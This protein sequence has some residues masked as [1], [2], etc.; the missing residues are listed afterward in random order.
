MISRSLSFLAALVAAL[1]AVPPAGASTG[2][3]AMFQDDAELVYPSRA[4]VGRNLDTLQA[5][6]VDRVRVSVYWRLVAPSPAS[7]TRPSFGGAGPADPAAYPREHWRRYDDLVRLAYDRGIQV[8][9]NIGGPA[10][11]WASGGKGGIVNPR[12]GDF[13]QFVAAVAT[14]YTGSYEPPPGNQNPPPPPPPNPNPLPVEVQFAPRQAEPAAVSSQQPEPRL[15]RVSYWSIYNEPNQRVFLTPQY[16][17]RREWSPRLYRA[18]ADAA[19][20][21][22]VRTGHGGDTVLVGET[23]PKG[24]GERDPEANMRPLRFLRALYCVDTRFRPLRGATAEALGCPTSNQVAEFPRLHP[25]LFQSSGFAHHPYSLLTP[26]AIR[27][28]NRDDV[29]MADIGRLTGALNAVAATYRQRNRLSIY[30]TEFGYQSRPPDPFGF[31][32][33]L[34]AK[35]INQAEYM[36]YVNG[37]VRSAHQ[38]L[39]VDAPP[40]TQYP[41]NSYQYWSSFQTGLKERGGASKQAFEAYRMPIFIPA[42][43]RRR[44][45]TFRVWGGVR[46]AA[47][48]SRQRVEVQYKSFARGA[49]WR[50]IRTVEVRSLRNYLDT[51]VRISRTGVVR[52][53]WRG[54]TS[55]PE[56]VTIG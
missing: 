27:S 8:N 48:G 42:A 49:D 43:R 20:D 44:P 31:P 17:D 39:L 54:L 32:E 3:E 50:T 23:A 2:Q 16:V 7:E 18:L 26:P 10:P 34:Q 13:G 37:R 28:A 53:R 1:L 41:S 52:L 14:R 19:F 51:R 15:P 5:L 45:G 47:N 55:R 30:N 22:L 33:H 6:G 24:G 29:G 25:V 46:P 35:Y 21:A 56:P 38:F 36:G 11:D 12:A 4:E 9:F 40:Y